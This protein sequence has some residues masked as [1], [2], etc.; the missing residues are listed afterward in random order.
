MH[1]KVK[2][3]MRGE[4][5]MAST[6]SKEYS[7]VNSLM[8]SCSC[9]WKFFLRMSAFLHIIR[10]WSCKA[11]LFTAHGRLSWEASGSPISGCRE[12]HLVI[13]QCVM[14]FIALGNQRIWPWRGITWSKKCIQVTVRLSWDYRW[15]GSALNLVASLWLH[16]SKSSP[17]K[18]MY[19]CFKF[20]EGKGK[21]H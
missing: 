16:N 14:G 3:E 15:W 20:R 10:G 13:A 7:S 21:I 4:Y 19:R 17:L 1:Y 9:N 18:K 2:S 5:L 8:I 12:G 11:S 6:I